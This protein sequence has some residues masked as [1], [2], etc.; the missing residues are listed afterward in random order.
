MNDETEKKLIEFVKKF[1]DI[2][3]IR[4]TWYGGEPLLKLDRIRSLTEQIKLVVPDFSAYMITNGYLLTPNVI[5]E[6]DNLHI[7]SLQ[8]TIDGLEETHNKRRPHV[9]EK[10]S[11]QKIIQN[12]E[13]FFSKYDDKSIAL[14]VNIDSSNE[15]EFSLLY[16]YLLA[17]FKGKKL[18]V[19]PGYITNIYSTGTCNSI[20]CEFDR[21]M[22]SKFMLEQFEK[23][24]IQ[25]LNFFPAISIGECCARH[26]NSFVIGP[27]GEIYKCWND[28]GVSNKEIGNIHSAEIINPTLAT[29][30]LTGA[31]PLE[32]INCQGCFYSVICGGGCTY[33]RLKNKFENANIDT[34]TVVKGKLDKFLK[35]HYLTKKQQL[36]V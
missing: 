34:C 19:H 32:D 21:E 1:D 27:E 18:Y 2:N 7:E 35:I 4:V 10:D 23:K 9:T 13:Y 26:I 30:Y 11:F 22:K 25:T 5:D 3:R 14:R 8:V 6:L 36:V 28:I 33:S 29:N 17:K 16:K 20:N 12:M 24:G 31:D 15:T